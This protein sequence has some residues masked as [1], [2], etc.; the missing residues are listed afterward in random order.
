MYTLEGVTK[1]Y[2]TTFSKSV[3]ALRGVSLQLGENGLVAILG[4]SGCG[5]STLLNLLAGL[6]YPTS[7][8]IRFSNNNAG[9]AIDS[10]RNLDCYRAADIGIVFQDFQLIPELTVGQNLELVL[11][12]IEGYSKE[13]VE[14]RIQEALSFVDLDGLENRFVRELSGGQQ[15]RVAI[16]RAFIK[17]PLVI[18]ADEPTG[19]LDTEN[20]EIVFHLLKR[21]SK[22]CLVIV[23]T[24]DRD[25]AQQYADRILLMRDGV[26]VEDYKNETLQGNGQELEFEVINKNKV[27]A[28]P[29]AYLVKMAWG[30]LRVRRVRLAISLILLSIILALIKVILAV[31]TA[32]YGRAFEEL[33]RSR[34]QTF[35]ASRET[36]YYE[37]EYCPYSYEDRNSTRLLYTIRDLFGECV[38]GKRENIYIFSADM[39]KKDTGHIDTAPFVPENYLLHGHFPECESDIVLTDYLRDKLDLSGEALG[40]E[41]M[42]DGVVFRVRGIIETDY[43]TLFSRGSEYEIDTF[44]QNEGSRV[45]VSQQAEKYWKSN[46]K[47]IPLRCATIDEWLLSNYLD[48]I[49]YYGSVQELGVNDLI[50]G[51]F[52]ENNNEI[53]LSESYV[54]CNPNLGILIDSF[55]EV[56]FKYLN[57]D[58]SIQQDVFSGY[59]NM[60]SDFQNPRIV[61]VV[62]SNNADVYVTEEQFSEVRDSFYSNGLYDSYLIYIG[63]KS[64]FSKAFE[65]LLSEDYVISG[66]GTEGLY[67]EMR[68]NDERIGVFGK[69]ILWVLICILL[70]TLVVFFSFNVRDNERKIGVLRSMGVLGTDVFKLMLFEAILLSV[71]SAVLSFAVECIYYFIQNR[72][73]QQYYGYMFGVYTVNPLL[74]LG[75]I[76]VLIISAIGCVFLP[77]WVMMGKPIIQMIKSK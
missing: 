5:K 57:L 32:N 66:N 65:H 15:Q 43:R 19:N 63:N 40:D 55:E 31:D 26:V 61:G 68:H 33:F 73:L 77:L 10:G 16:A 4:K 8:S 24:H 17:R 14:G 49:T 72:S 45:I 38:Y 39:T 9:F 60:Y 23:S 11:S 59:L 35:S 3:M 74:E 30:G 41:V 1:E 76:L 69:I 37:G 44:V 34:E 70:L 42:I 50:A 28:I 20:S 13:E 21:L 75:E 12:Q 67:H 46:A 29:F 52:P 71:V 6:D 53:L 22:N 27:Q 47:Y 48:T 62:S 58:E 18:L 51:R 7:G 56:E 64:G 2:K 25:E 36:V 54:Y